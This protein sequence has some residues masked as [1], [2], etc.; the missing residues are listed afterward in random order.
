MKTLVAL[1]VTLC[2]TVSFGQNLRLKSGNYPIDKMVDL[3]ENSSSFDDQFAIIV[4]NETPTSI[5]KE[6]L[7]SLGVTLF[8]YLPERSFYAKLNTDNNL[9]NLGILN[10]NRI[11]EIKSNYKLTKELNEGIY[12]AHAISS[13]DRVDLI[14][15]YFKGVKTE[16]LFPEN[17]KVE[18]LESNP[19]IQQ[20]TIRVNLAQLEELY[21]IPGIYS[22]ESI[23]EE[24]KPENKVERTNHRANFLRSSDA[25]GLFYRG[26]GVKVMMQDDGYISH[27]DHI[28]RVDQSMC[29]GCSSSASNS[30]GDHVSGTIMGAGN[31]DPKGR[32]MADGVDLLVFNSS[33][34][35]YNSV[36]SL[37]AN[38]SLV[39][40]SK[41]YSGGC[42]SGYT[43]LSRQ[44]DQQIRQMPALIHVFSAGNSGTSNCGYGAGSGWGNITGG[45]KAGKNVI[46]VGNLSRYDGIAN[47]SSR[48]P[49]EDGRIKPDICGVG[50]SVFS[51][52]PNN[53]YATISGTSMS[54]PG[55]AGTIALLYEAYRDNFGTN[56]LSGLIKAS[57]LNTGE[58]LGNA[59]PD[60][61]YGWGRINAR[62]AYETFANNQFIYDSIAQ[63]NSNSHVINVPAG[64]QE[65]RVMVY[66]MDYEGSTTSAL[67]LVND[68]NMIVT[69][70]V[71]ATFQ[72]WILDPTPNA[73]TLNNPAV[74]GTDNLNNMEQVTI[75]NPTA[76]NYTIDVDGFNIPQGPQTYHLVYYF[77]LDDITVIYPNG[78]EPF[79]PSTTEIIRWDALENGSDY[80]VEYTED[81][82][83]TWNSIGTAPANRL[84]HNWSV[85]STLTGLAKVRITRG[86]ISDESDRIFDIID[87]PN[88]LSFGWAC[89]DSARLVWDSV[90]GALYYEVSMLGNKYMDSIGT[91][92][93]NSFTMIQPANN[94]GWY[95]V[96]AVGADDAR[97]ER[98]IAIQKSG[99]EFACL[100]STPMAVFS[101]DCDDAGT[102]YCVNLTNQ[103]INADATSTYTWYFPGGTPATATGENPNVCYATSGFYD[104]A[105]VVDNGFAIDSVYTTNALRIKDTKT[106]PYFE[107]FE[108]YTS[109]NGLD[110]WSITNPD[111]N[112][113]WSVFPN[114][115]LSGTKSARL[116]N[117]SQNGNYTDE[118]ISGPLDLST[119][120]ATASMTLSF[121]YSYRKKNI[122][123]T[124]WLR[125]YVTKNCADN[126]VLRKTVSGNNLSSLTSNSNWVPTDSSDWTTVHMTNIT[127]IFYTGDFR[128]K[129]SFESDA[130]NSIYLDDINIYEG[131]PSDE[132]VGLTEGS[133]LSGLEIYPNPAENEVNI[134]YSLENAQQTSVYLLG[135][136]GNV[137]DVVTV[138][139][140]S[141]KNLIIMD[142]SNYASGVYFLKIGGGESQVTKKMVIK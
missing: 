140:N 86:G 75:L 107:G 74:R 139:S 113:G 26:T 137:I 104:V 72:P 5:D 42:N 23:P 16:A 115:A 49:A 94:T 70:P 95:S 47:S 51:T 98:H 93:I 53:T 32:G 141:G 79:E 124:E 63:G 58:D 62:R 105:L 8:S 126:W 22:F 65:L 117:Y 103:S 138:N 41:S 61:T 67:A 14:C 136:T 83:A 116:Y 123:N 101:V 56:P 19:S 57:I 60:F 24:S 71:A 125:I 69:D 68:I 87:V 89:P 76:G 131:A 54:C 3:R 7:A 59:G 119:L 99:S 122:S 135:L 36:P 11:V 108:N 37:Y 84:Y 25:T 81:N 43:S 112:A 33:D 109:F 18:V 127:N 80:T 111:G 1:V 38:D 134:S 73:T 45:H 91:S 128:F 142:L 120:A 82:G 44:L 118:L 92:V 6:R 17:L 114:A 29:S 85:P 21:V 28:G 129:F 106:L 31:L 20:L 132:I 2:F 97:S 78:G 130:G 50:S 90:P 13:G 35:G 10:I 30:H 40:T 34:A 100:W 48:G 88:N 110:E 39:I 55:V 121:R 12:A 15:N 9:K 52:Y 96:I 102:G 133:L 46:A 66:W 64:V 77:V 4:F 27:I